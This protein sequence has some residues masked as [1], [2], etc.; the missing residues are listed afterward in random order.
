MVVTMYVLATDHPSHALPSKGFAL[1]LGGGVVAKTPGYS[2]PVNC[3][4]P[5][6]GVRTCD[7]YAFAAGDMTV[8]PKGMT[9]VDA[10][11]PF[12]N[13]IVMNCECAPPYLGT[14]FS[15]AAHQPCSFRLGQRVQLL[16]CHAA[17]AAS[18]CWACL[19]VNG[20]VINQL[21]HLKWS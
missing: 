12:P 16:L 3:T 7:N 9:D 20:L 8:N 10:Y 1:D 11:A 14:G 13:A 2:G 21:L 15:S 6:T 5:V 17:L 19:I 18:V 4:D